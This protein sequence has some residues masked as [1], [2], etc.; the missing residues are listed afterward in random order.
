MILKPRIAHNVTAICGGVF[1]AYLGFVCAVVIASYASIIPAIFGLLGLSWIFM[2]SLSLMRRSRLAITIDSS[3]IGLPT[4]S[5]VRGDL[6]NIFV[7]SEVIAAILRHES[8]KGR[9]IVITLK[10]GDRVPIQARNYCELKDFLRLCEHAG[11]PV[12]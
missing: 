9:V 10:T 6:R 12:I 5:I 7:P 4:G 2:G 3:G 1:I 11:L 8:L